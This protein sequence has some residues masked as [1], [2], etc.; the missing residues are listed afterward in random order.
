MGTSNGRNTE[1]KKTSKTIV[2]KDVYKYPL[3]ESS[4][5]R[6]GSTITRTSTKKR[7]VEMPSSMGLSPLNMSSTENSALNS[8]DNKLRIRFTENNETPNRKNLEQINELN[9]PSLSV[10]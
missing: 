1:M 10:I 3:N 6:G 2:F 9:S 5:R 4:L 7:Y 8:S